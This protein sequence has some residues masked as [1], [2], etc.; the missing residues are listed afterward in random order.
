MAQKLFSS[1][2]SALKESYQQ[3]TSKQ[4]LETWSPL[5]RIS[6]P[7]KRITIR[8]QITELAIISALLCQLLEWMPLMFHDSAITKFTLVSVFMK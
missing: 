4:L 3:H 7:W 2:L 8:I 6:S 1:V 5:A